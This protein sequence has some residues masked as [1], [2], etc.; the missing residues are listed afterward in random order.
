MPGMSFQ[1][2]M[3]PNRSSFK[4]GIASVDDSM[5]EHRSPSLKAFSPGQVDRFYTQGPDFHPSTDLDD[6]WVT[7]FGFPSASAYFILDQFREYGTIL[8]YEVKSKKY[9][10]EHFF[11]AV[12]FRLI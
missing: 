4:N 6:T 11:Q 12:D 2:P 1:S 8:R 9:L 7:V 5:F 10:K 3:T